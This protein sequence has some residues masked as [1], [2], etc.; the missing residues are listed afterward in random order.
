MAVTFLNI[1][2]SFIT[3]GQYLYNVVDDKIYTVKK[4][5]DGKVKFVDSDMNYII[6]DQYIGRSSHKIAEE[7]WYLVPKYIVKQ[8]IQDSPEL[9]V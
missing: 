1:S 9:F 2:E 4:V 5:S 8:F 7:G 6:K 3:A